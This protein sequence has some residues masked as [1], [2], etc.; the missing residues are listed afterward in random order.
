MNPGEKV[1]IV[2]LSG[3]G[4]STAI[5]L[6]QRFYDAISGEVLIDGHDV[7]S[8]DVVWLRSQFGVVAQQADLFTGTIAL[9]IRIGAVE[10]TQEEIMDSA[11]LASA[12]QF[13]RRLPEGYDIWLTE[14]GSKLSG[15]Q[16]Q[17]I[18]IA[19]AL[20]RRP[21]VIQYFRLRAKKSSCLLEN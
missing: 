18:A 10:A 21:K 12:D 16:R 9:H 6:I 15:G 5:Q 19:R 8:L 2:G 11:K 3:S 17:R 7:R 13:I 4:K 1:A 14:G 20:I